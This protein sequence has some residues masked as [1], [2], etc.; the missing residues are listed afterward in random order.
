MASSVAGS[1][2]ASYSRS[3]SRSPSQ[4]PGDTPSAAVE[5]G[6]RRLPAEE[7]RGYLP[8]ANPP[9]RL[10]C[11]FGARKESRLT[12]E[13]TRTRPRRSDDTTTH[14]SSAAPGDLDW[15]SI[16]SIRALAMDAVEAAQSGHPG[17]PMALAPA[18]Y[19][20]WHRFLRHNPRN[21]HWPDRDRFVLSCG[22][23]S[24]LLYALLYLTGYDLSLDDLKAFRQWGSRT[25]GHPERGH[26]PGVETTTGPLGQGVAN[27][28]GM[29][30]AERLLS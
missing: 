2:N 7:R 15:R 3:R 14:V 21:P 8:G 1:S 28:V 16:N 25:P 6:R 30:I 19:V 29:A 12:A 4:A 13:T 24:M 11:E 22:H 27:A 10:R 23:A 9:F 20:L 17:T 5:A 18:A 26:T